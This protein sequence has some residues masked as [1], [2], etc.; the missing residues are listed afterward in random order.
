MDNDMDM[1]DMAVGAVALHELYCT[2]KEAGFT[3]EE[4][5]HLTAAAMNGAQQS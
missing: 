5:I 4:A 2:F 3:A 1:T